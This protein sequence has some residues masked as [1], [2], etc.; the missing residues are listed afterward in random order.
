MTAKIE[1]TVTPPK[2][3]TPEEFKEWLD[4]VLGQRADIALT[5]PNCDETIDYINCKA[6]ITIF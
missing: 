4:Y 3:C 2:S 1:L 6:K 5:N